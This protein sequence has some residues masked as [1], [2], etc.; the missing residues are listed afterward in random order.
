MMRNLFLAL[1]LSL[2]ASPVLATE[3]V[4]GTISSAE[5]KA[6]LEEWG[7]KVFSHED[8]HDRPQ[9][10]VNDGSEDHEDHQHGFAI[11]MTGCNP[12]DAVFY[13]RRCEGYQFRAYLTPGFPIEEK[14]YANW[15][16]EVGRTRAFVKEDHPRLVWDITIKGGVTWLNI[17]NT[18]E[19]WRGELEEYIDH[20]DASVLE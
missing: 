20:L 6:H 3:T 1:L 8:E 5:L 19:T 12:A 17:R 11:R 4:V 18:V 16:R 7:Y 15:N 10:L 9:L 13:D 2:L 14:I